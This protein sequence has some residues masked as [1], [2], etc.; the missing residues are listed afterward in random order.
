MRSLAI[1]IVLSVSSTLVAEPPI[2]SGPPMISTPGVLAVPVT[3]NTPAPRG[4]W[5]RVSRRV[6]ALAPWVARYRVAWVYVEDYPYP[7]PQSRE[8]A[9]YVPIRQQA[10]PSPT[11]PTDVDVRPPSGS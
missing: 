10:Q 7:S 8:G 5:V 3:I 4:R 9:T 6:P 1:V 2:Y 11:R